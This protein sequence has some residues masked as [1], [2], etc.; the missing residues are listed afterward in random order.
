MAREAL[1]QFQW[2]PQTSVQVV[3]VAFAVLQNTHAS[4][5]EDTRY[6][7]G[8]ECVDDMSTKDWMLLLMKVWPRYVG[9]LYVD[10]KSKFSVT[11]H[12]WG[13]ACGTCT[14]GFL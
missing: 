6:E 4:A 12:Q 5:V 13:G 9:A 2:L 11:P 8:L 10:H 7:V 1:D 3:Q 14:Y